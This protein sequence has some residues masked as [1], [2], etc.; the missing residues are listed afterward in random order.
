MCL[1][2]HNHLRFSDGHPAV[3]RKLLRFFLLSEVDVDWAGQVRRLLELL[4]V[5][6]HEVVIDFGVVDEDM[7]QEVKQ[8]HCVVAEDA[9]A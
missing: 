5:L 3:R 6:E 8:C 9:L 1:Q 4:L 7:V 2:F